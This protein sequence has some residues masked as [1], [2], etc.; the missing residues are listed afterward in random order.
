MH[1]DVRAIMER[2]EKNAQHFSGLNEHISG[3]TNMLALNAT[4]EAL[5]AGDAGRGFAVVAGEVKNLA[6]QAASNS[7]EFRQKMAEQIQEGLKL[8]EQLATDADDNRYVSMAHT[9]VQYIVRNLYER[10]ADVRWWATEAAFVDALTNLTP[11]D[12]LNASG[13]LATINRYYSLYMNLVLVDT[14]GVIVAVSRPDR[15]SHM[16]GAHVDAASW[17]QR[18]IKTANGN[19]YISDDIHR[20]TLHGNKLVSIFATAVRYGG[21]L[22]AVPIGVLAIVFDWENQARGIVCDE[23]ALSDEEKKCSRVLLLDSEHRIIASS[24]NKNLLSAFPLPVDQK[25]GAYRVDN[26]MIVH[27]AQT[28]G[29]QEYDGQGWYGVVII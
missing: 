9:L 1:R 29:Y 13:R 19:D 4:I 3:K 23:A 7:R 11:D 20:C 26:G 2:L 10:T 22:H 15:Y 5:R 12:C 17:F 18:G 25:K 21:D 8:T 27:F 24:D 14:K 16:V 6:S 28:S